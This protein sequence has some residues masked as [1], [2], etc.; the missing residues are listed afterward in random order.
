MRTK[1]EAMRTKG[2]REAIRTKRN[3]PGRRECKKR[4][5]AACTHR[6]T[7]KIES[8]AR[9]ANKNRNFQTGRDGA[10]NVEQ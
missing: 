1:R 10:D 6:V 2:V 7:A 4:K 9:S 3:P 5:A 8:L